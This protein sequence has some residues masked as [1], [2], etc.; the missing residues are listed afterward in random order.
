MIICNISVIFIV[1]K[2][3]TN[4]LRAEQLPYLEFWV[5]IWFFRESHSSASCCLSH[6]MCSN[7]W[8]RRRS[9]STMLSYSILLRLTRWS[10][11]AARIRYSSLSCNKIKHH[12][13]IPIHRHLH[14]K[15]WNP[16]TALT[17]CQFTFFS[18]QITWQYHCFNKPPALKLIC[19]TNWMKPVGQSIWPN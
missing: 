8:C 5:L 2:Q 4:K 19:I 14:I 1:T 15:K 16:F 3:T 6:L 17:T 18:I 7:S 11:S 13:T 9:L 10:S 12:V